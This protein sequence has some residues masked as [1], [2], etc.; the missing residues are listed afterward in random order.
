MGKNGPAES[1]C[2]LGLEEQSHN[3]AVMVDP[4]CI[5]GPCVSPICAGQS[6]LQ[7]YDHAVGKGTFSQA[8]CALDMETNREECDCQK[9]MKL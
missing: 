4:S 7:R 9:T 6:L 5:G 8:W 3:L 1:M 2:R